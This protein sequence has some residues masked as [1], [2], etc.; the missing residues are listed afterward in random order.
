[1][2]RVSVIVPTYNCAR[3]LSKALRSAQEQTYSDHEIIVVDDGS[4][5]GTREVAAKYGKAIRYLWQPNKGV[6]AARNLG[7]SF[8]TGEFVAYLDADDM[9]YHHKLERQ[10]M[11]LDANK[12]YG[13]VH[14]DIDIINEDDE[15][16]H[17]GFNQKTGRN[18]PQGRCTAQLFQLL[19][20]C[21][22]QLPSVVV[23]REYVTRVGNF[24]VRLKGTEDY[25][26]WILIAMEGATL[27]YI[28]EPLAMYRWTGGS[29]SSG[30][31]WMCEDL[32]RMLRI[33][34][35]EKCLRQR[36]GLEAVNIIRQRIYAL[37]N[38]LAYL[39]RIEGHLPQARKRLLGLISET[40]AQLNLYIDLFKASI[41]S[42]V[43]RQLRTL[44]GRI[45]QL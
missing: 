29:I 7:L 37:N 6:S 9:W 1:M 25:L 42:R 4:T 23:R 12:Q 32:M 16:I 2:P 26:Q 5:D 35:N 15:V 24:D 44:K 17:H 38:E 31:R 45:L 21:H 43:M 22:V 39:E 33:L 14:S 41:P 11:F 19:Q 34:L 27:G 18:V 40:P 13:L 30:S 3:F 10:I 36:C 8:A 28:G 20:E